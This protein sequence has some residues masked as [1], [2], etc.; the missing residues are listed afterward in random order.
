MKRPG[1]ASASS[2]SPAKDGRL[3]SSRRLPSLGGLAAFEAAARL[4]GLG[5]AANELSVTTSAISHQ[6]RALEVQLGMPLFDRSTRPL[7]LTSTGRMLLPALRGAFDAI[8]DRLVSLGAGP[9]RGELRVNCSPLLLAKRVLPLLS[10]FL[11]ANRELNLSISTQSPPPEGCDL[12]ISFGEVDAPGERKALLTGTPLPFF[13][14][15]SPRLLNRSPGIRTPNDILRHPLIHYDD[16]A[17]WRRLIA[18]CGLESEVPPTRLTVPHPLMA[19]DL[20]ALGAGF[21]IAD[22]MTAAEELASGRLVRIADTE[23]DAPEQ[24]LMILPTEEPKRR[25]VRALEHFLLERL[26]ADPGVE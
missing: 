16:G 2:S 25:R 12:I 5:Q 10:E 15:C 8:A 6:V 9:M 18:T 17:D 26:N 14:V 20:A 7:A 4:G 22:A 3:L 1:R 21:A 11:D 19:F 23:M 13:A 24:Y